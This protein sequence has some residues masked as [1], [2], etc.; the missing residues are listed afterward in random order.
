MLFTFDLVSNNNNSDI[1]RIMEQRNEV[2]R[3]ILEFFPADMKIPKENLTDFV[4]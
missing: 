1:A 3:N 4:Q 2:F